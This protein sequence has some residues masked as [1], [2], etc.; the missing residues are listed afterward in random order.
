MS[1]INLDVTYHKAQYEIFFGLTERFRIV[2]KGRRFGLT[3]GAAQAFIRW[4]LEEPDYYLWGDT[5]HS[6]I[7]K[8]VTRYFMPILKQ[9]PKSMWDWG[10]QAKMLS[11]G[12][13]QLD[14]RSADNPE[15]WEGF[16][17]KKIFLNEAGIILENEYLWENAVQPM[18]LDRADSVCI[19]GGTPKGE[20]KFHELHLRGLSA[21]YP[22][23][24]TKQYSSYDNPYLDPEEIT[25]M[26]ADMDDD[27]MRQEIF[28]DFLGSSEHQ[29]IPGSVVTS[30]MDRDVPEES[31]MF[32][33]VI[34]GVD[35]A[36]FGD[37]Q[38]V[39]A[40]RQGLK[41]HKLQAF[42][43]LRTTELASIIAEKVR[44]HQPKIRRVFVDEVG[45]GA[46]V[47]DRLVQLGLGDI[48]TGVNVGERAGRAE[49]YYNKRIEMWDVLKGW[50]EN[51]DIPKDN[52]LRADLIAPRYKFD[53]KERLQMER[54]EDI[55][56]R[57]GA[58]PDR[59]EALALTHAYPVM[60]VAVEQ[61]LEPE[62][63]GDF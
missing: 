10:K 62:Y 60:D 48:V 19:V 43:Q 46:G 61:S 40:L 18:L 59:A 31:Y 12:K 6:N 63:A 17:Y 38:S 49:R 20:N 56:K 11:I 28:G 44:T 36:R 24:V 2:H 23:W 14:F 37:D 9:L 53:N 51:A 35:V 55:K 13:S 29:L 39:I 1:V 22:D 16:G 34:M 33:P 32:S 30:A 26:A 5:V 4:M 47:V 54:K 21:A 27:V 42:G 41:L 58:S 25:R 15:N 45:V 52:G 3:R 50:L 57:L 8:Y 7:D